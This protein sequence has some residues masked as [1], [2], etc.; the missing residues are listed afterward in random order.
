[1]KIIGYITTFVVTIVLSTLWSGYVLSV[2]WRWFVVPPFGAPALSV[3]YAIG[4]ASVVG[5]LT[6]PY[7]SSKADE[8]TWS[9][10]LAEG[11]A[12]AALKP[13]FALLFGWVVTLFL[14]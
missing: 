1:M 13:A 9:A 6:Q 7:K 12:V 3:G 14:G 11:V 4:I 10:L 8:K 5:Y 2:L